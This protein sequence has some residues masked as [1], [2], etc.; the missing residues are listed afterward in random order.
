MC[1]VD[2]PVLCRM[3]GRRPQI[4]GTGHPVVARKTNSGVGRSEPVPAV[5]VAV[6]VRVEWDEPLLRIHHP[7]GS[8]A[9]RQP[10]RQTIRGPGGT[11]G[12]VSV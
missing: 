7:A 4:D 9:G 2:P 5:R 11:D 3:G 12:E 10:G 6:P 8:E 1:N